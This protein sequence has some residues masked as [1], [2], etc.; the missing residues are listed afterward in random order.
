MEIRIGEYIVEAIEG[1]TADGMTLD[2]YRLRVPGQDA[3]KI[4]VED[5]PPATPKKKTVVDPAIAR[6]AAKL[7]WVD[8]GGGPFLLVPRALRGEPARCP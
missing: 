5:A 8:T 2:L 1:H 6:A 3:A 4:V 7:K